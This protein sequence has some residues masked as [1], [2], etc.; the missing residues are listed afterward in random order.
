MEELGTHLLAV[1]LEHVL[2]DDL[3]LLL[4]DILH[5]VSAIVGSS[6]PSSCS[7][8]GVGDLSGDVGL[9]LER[10]LSLSKSKLLESV[11]EDDLVHG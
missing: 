1:S 6:S 11:L 7:T 8:G 10:V 9:N 5:V 2:L 3:L 4:V